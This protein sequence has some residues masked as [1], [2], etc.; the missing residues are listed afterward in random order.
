MQ[1]KCHLI[2]I[3]VPADKRTELKEQEKIFRKGREKEGSEKNLELGSSCGCSSCN[4]SPGSD[5]K[6]IERLAEKLNVKSDIELFLKQHCLE[7][8]KL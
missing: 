7:L 8:Q 5:I 6:K 3:T 1:K 4:W 2:D